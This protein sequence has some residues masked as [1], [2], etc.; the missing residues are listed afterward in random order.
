MYLAGTLFGGIGLG[1]IALHPPRHAPSPT[2]VANV[3]KTITSMGGDF[4]NAELSVAD[5]TVLRAWFFRAAHPNGSA[6]VLLHGV[7]DSRLGMYGYGR[8]LLESNY[9]VLL[10]DARAHGLSGGELATYGL[11]EADDIHQWVNW[12]ADNQKPTCIYGLGESMGAAQLLQSLRVE[13]RFC[14]VAAESPFETFR[15]VAY[16]R[17]GRQFHTGPWLG[18]TFFRPTIEVGMLFVRFRYGF[19]MELAS[20]ADVVAHTKIPVMLIH[21]L[22]D[23]NIP[24]YHSEDIYLRNPAAVT[25]WKVPAAIHTGAHKAAPQEF[26]RRLLEWFSVHSL[27]RP[28]GESE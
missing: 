18:R 24:P 28:T 23:R 13:Q 6:V 25:L 5:G 4:Q 14:A 20:P 11:L 12:L 15:E 7:G 19:N 8:W 9:S 17:F 3:E 1:W 2:E 10:P 27:P 26:E 16:A 22:A 21:G